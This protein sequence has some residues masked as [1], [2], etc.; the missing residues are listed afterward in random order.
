ML[1]TVPSR[2][3]FTIG[4]WRY[5]A[6]GGGPP[7]FPPDFSCPAVLTIHDHVPDTRAA[8]GPL[9]LFGRPFQ[10][11]SAL[12]CQQREGSTAPSITLVQPSH[13]SASQLVR[14]A[15]LGSS[16]FARRYS[17]NLLFSSRYSD[18]SLPAVP[19]QLSLG[20]GP[21]AHR[22]APFGFSGITG[23]QRLPQTFRRVAASFLGRHRQGIHPAPFFRTSFS[24]IVP[25]VA[26]SRH[27]RSVLRSRPARASKGRIL[28][29]LGQVDR[30]S[31]RSLPG[32]RRPCSNRTIGYV[33]HT[34]RVDDPARPPGSCLIH[35]RKTRRVSRGALSRCKKLGT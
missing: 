29:S 26:R 6:L 13:G 31:S 8:Y 19:S 16:P 17:G 34:V 28:R 1:F 7:C 35:G 3:W 9:T 27:A 32:S 20:D 33:A 11:R 15:S 23:C 30:R 21:C 5:L 12:V 14:R 18:V 4:R 24:S 25:L 10:W 22:V 2:Y